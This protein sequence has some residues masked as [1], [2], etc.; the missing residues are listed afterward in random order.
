[1]G[2]QLGFTVESMPT[3]ILDGERVSST[4]VRQALVED[5]Q[6]LV[7]R[8]LGHS[9]CMLGRISHGDQRGRQWGFP[10]ANIF[11][12]RKLTPVRGVY[13]VYM[14]GIAREAWPGV[15]NIGQRPTVDGTRTLLEVHLLDFN[16][17][18]YGC[19]VQ[20]EF[21]KKLRDEI[22]FPHWELLK[23]QIT[24]DVVEA[25]DYFKTLE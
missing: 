6:Q 18:I 2:E 20:V 12:H 11:L 4:R 10:T 13:T 15:A 9:Y 22:R 8:L 25:R 16:Q 3:L 24:Q 23:Q 19:Y 14:H 1:M 21:C 5:N 17:E 7:K